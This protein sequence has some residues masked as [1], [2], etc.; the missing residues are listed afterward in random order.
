MGKKYVG[1]GGSTLHD[2]GVSRIDDKGNIEFAS[3][4]ERYTKKKHDG[5]IP[6]ELWEAVCGTDVIADLDPDITIVNSDDWEVREKFRKGF[7]NGARRNA[8]THLSNTDPW[9]FQKSMSGSTVN[10]HHRSHACS[11]LMTRPTNFE[12]SDCVTVVVDGVG[13]YRSAAIYNS[14]LELV[15]EMLFPKSIGYL[16][17]FFT[18]A[19]PDMKLKANEDEY[20]VMGLSSYGEPTHWEKVYDMFECTIEHCP[21]TKIDIDW[22][23]MYAFKL[24]PL[25]AIVSMLLTECKTYKTQQHHYSTQPKK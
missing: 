24:Q 21:E 23:R 22:Q 20:V 16:Y 2:A 13:E 8:G 17:A 3:L 15:W 14:E 12:R 1:V 11:T 18:T 5:T 25:K 7:L 19:I 9:N 4:S 6:P 10:E